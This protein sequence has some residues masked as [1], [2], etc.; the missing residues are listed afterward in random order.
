MDIEAGILEMCNIEVFPFLAS[1]VNQV[2]RHTLS[3]HPYSEVLIGSAVTPVEVDEMLTF[4][5]GAGNNQDR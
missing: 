3:K 1:D 4:V 5:S 2:D